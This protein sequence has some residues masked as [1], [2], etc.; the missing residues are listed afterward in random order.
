MKLYNNSIDLMQSKITGVPLE[1]SALGYFLLGPM[2]G[3]AVNPLRWRI[4]GGFATI[5]NILLQ[6][7]SYYTFF[8][9]I[10]TQDATAIF[11]GG[12]IF[13]S[14]FISIV[15]TARSHES[16]RQTLI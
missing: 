3:F 8:S 10:V 9:G 5:L 16:Y 1:P 13:T 4:L 7:Y 12:V 2:K 14:S 15:S 11:L 6:P